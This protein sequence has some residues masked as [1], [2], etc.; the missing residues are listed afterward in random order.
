M[1]GCLADENISHSLV[2]ALRLAGVEVATVEQLELAGT[3][4]SAIAAAAL[5]DQRLVLTND[6]DFL[7]LAA[8]ARGNQTVL[9]PIVFWPQQGRRKIRVLV[10]QIV[11]LT[12]QPDYEQLC[13]LVHYL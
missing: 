3:D 11:P 2:H 4:D 10:S 13:G 9:A 5:R 6:T 1:W 12:R 7:R 8:E